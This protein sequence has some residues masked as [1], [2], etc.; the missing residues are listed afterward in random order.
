MRASTYAWFT[1]ERAAPL[2]TGGGRPRAAAPPPPPPP[3]PGPGGGG[4]HAPP[5]RGGGAHGDRRGPPAVGRSPPTPAPGRGP[6][7]A[8]TS[9][10][11]SEAARRAGH[12]RATELRRRRHEHHRRRQPQPL[13]PR[14]PPGPSRPQIRSRPQLPPRP[15]YRSRFQRFRLV[16]CCR[17]WAA[18][19]RASRAETSRCCVGEARFAEANLGVFLTGA[20]G[21][22]IYGRSAEPVICQPSLTR[23]R[24]T[25][26]RRRPLRRTTVARFPSIVAATAS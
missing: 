8:R 6:G 19:G 23:V 5:P 25:C 4:R 13:A 21:T 11:R 12:R 9:G 14:S 26:L 15:I 1:R 16:N 20:G 24:L 22:V 2:A 10:D 18:N 7:G 17:P 3:A